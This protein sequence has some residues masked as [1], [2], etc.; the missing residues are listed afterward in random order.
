V[1]RLKPA[2]VFGGSSLMEKQYMRM[3][4]YF[5]ESLHIT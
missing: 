5:F 1:G 2:N 3:G 4:M